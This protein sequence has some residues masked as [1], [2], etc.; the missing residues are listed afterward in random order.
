MISEGST[1]YRCVE[2][3]T[4][5]TSRQVSDDTPGASDGVWY[6]FLPWERR[7]NTKTSH[8]TTCASVPGGHKGAVCL[9]RVPDL[10]V[11]DDLVG[12]HAAVLTEHA[13]CTAT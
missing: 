13:R 12:Y 2:P 3:C 1:S 8:A 11:A 6:S 9:D 4:S 7:Q 10:Q 5:V